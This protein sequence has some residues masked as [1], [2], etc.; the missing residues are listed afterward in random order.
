M[1]KIGNEDSIVQ[2]E[3]KIFSIAAKYGGIPGGERNG[4]RGYNLTFVIAYIR[5]HKFLINSDSIIMC[6][7]F[8]N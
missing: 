7:K 5:V 8:S 2:Q 6:R 3:A 1:D 4:E